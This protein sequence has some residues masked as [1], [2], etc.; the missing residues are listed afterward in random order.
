MKTFTFKK[1]MGI[2][3]LAMLLMSWS[4]S[5]QAPVFFETCGEE[6]KTTGT[7]DTPADYTGWDNGAPITFDGTSDVRATTQMNTHVWFAANADKDLIISGIN[8]SGKTDLKLSFKIACGNSAGNAEK[9]SVVVKDLNG[10]SDIPITVPSTTFSG[11]NSF[12]DISNLS[13]VPATTNLRITFTVAA[14]NNPTGHGYRLDDIKIT[15][16]DAP[17]LSTNNNLATLTVSTG[18]LSPEF[19]SETT[20]YTVSLPEGTTAVPTVNYTL[21]DTKAS[22]LKTDAAAIP[23]ITTVVVT[24]ENG[25]KKTYSIS[26]SAAKPAG[27]WFEDFES[28][29]T[30]NSYAVGDYQGSAALWEA[31]AVINHDA[32][33]K[34]N[35]ETSARLRDPNASNADPHY[36]LMKE[37]KPLGAGVISLYHGMYGTHTGGAYTLEVSNNGGTTWNAFSAEVEEVPT[38]WEKVSFT[39]NVEG[40][41]RIKIT[42]TSATNSSTIN[43]DDIQI[44]DYPAN[45]IATIDNDLFVYTAN[46]TLFVKNLN[47]KEKISIYDIAGKLVNQ[48]TATE[49]P[50]TNKGIYIVRIN[51]HVF[52][53]INK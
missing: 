45:S 44:T 48:T 8:T 36:I 15:S 24:A 41:I 49:I 30:K 10:G 3:L 42:K 19:D 28:T 5:A 18:T 16:G 47:E 25:A 37:D 38:T 7:R 11:S 32:N 33:D 9:L 50:L 13:G 39:A 53:V 51:S 26:F 40:N 12:I 31:F 34:R 21:E 35:G 43:I 6:G 17:V 4:I 27:A 29:E 22:A 1:W 20:S 2:S 23:G 46:S 52:K 14:A